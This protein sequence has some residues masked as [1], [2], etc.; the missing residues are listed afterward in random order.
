MGKRMKKKSKKNKKSGNAIKPKNAQV[1]L[2]ESSMNPD[3]PVYD[4]SRTTMQVLQ[5]GT[6]ANALKM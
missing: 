1:S 4:F 5:P 6:L 2:A 3:I